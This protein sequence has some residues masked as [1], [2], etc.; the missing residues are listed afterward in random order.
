MS[1]LW[2]TFQTQYRPSV[3]YAVS[4]VL[5]ESTRPAR[6]A[7]PVLTR[8]SED[9]GAFVVASRAP[10]LASVVPPHSQSSAQLGD[11]LTVT[12]DGLD[13]K[14]RVRMR[15]RYFDAPIELDPRPGG[16]S[17]ERHVHLPSVDED[18]A[19]MANWTPG[20]FTADVA[21]ETT[22]IPGRSLASN[23]V[24]WALAPR[25]TVAP[26]KP[27][28]GAVVLTVTCAPRL[29]DERPERPDRF[30]QRV[31]LLLSRRSPGGEPDE[32]EYQVEITSKEN[33]ESLAAPTKLTFRIPKLVVGQYQVRLRVDGVDSIPAVR[34][35][36]TGR[37]QFDERQMIEVVA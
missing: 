23:E 6:A 1:K 14:V 25:I 31:L 28:A 13:A 27:N 26:P 15:S 19:A 7:L 18:A 9:G 24:A 34:R 37:F 10:T 12:G 22:S 2:T 32:Q 29:R 4:V 11:D 20:F 16:S 33:P 8:G 5:I 21:A 3:A 35:E 30:R 17:S 36:D